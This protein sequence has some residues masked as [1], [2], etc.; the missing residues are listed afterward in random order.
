MSRNWRIP[1]FVPWKTP[2]PLPADTAG[3][4][5]DEEGASDN[6]GLTMDRLLAY[7]EDRQRQPELVRDFADRQALVPD[8]TAQ[9]DLIA[10]QRRR[11]QATAESIAAA[12][13]TARPEWRVV[14]G[15][16]TNQILQGGMTLHH[17]YGIPFV[18]ASALKGI[19]RLYA[20]AVADTPAQVVNALFG[21]VDAVEGRRGDLVF[22]DGIAIEPPQVERDVMNPLWAAYYG[23]AD[24]VPAADYINPR[25][26]FFLTVAKESRFLFGLGSISG[27]AEAVEQG[28]TWL[29]QGLQELGS[30]AKTAAG[31]GYWVVDE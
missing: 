10:G 12:K 30:G 16:G 25:P 31:Y 26:A 14:I 19:T 13:F 1:R 29:K 22:L 17:V 28:I 20:E 24:R 8:Y 15:L 21:H 18:P 6:A 4:L 9:A 11:W 5:M 27:D 7:G 23:G 3:V 2:Y